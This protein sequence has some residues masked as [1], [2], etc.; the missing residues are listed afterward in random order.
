MTRRR[1]LPW[2]A[3]RGPGKRPARRPVE[4]VGGVCASVSVR[5]SVCVCAR[6]RTGVGVGVGVGLWVRVY[7]RVCVRACVRVYMCSRSSGCCCCCAAAGSGTC[8]VGG[9][10][11][12]VSELAMDSCND[13]GCRDGRSY[14]RRKGVTLC[15]GKKDMVPIKRRK[16]HRPH[17]CSALDVL[18]IRRDDQARWFTPITG[19]SFFITDPPKKH[20]THPLAIEASGFPVR[21]R[22]TP[23]LSPPPGCA[24]GEYRKDWACFDG[25]VGKP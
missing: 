11:D 16:T 20:Q 18:T 7:V 1:T 2:A 3:A 23:A 25:I 5:A 12:T 21:E 15:Q 8:S 4:N 17:H 13:S 6:V 24:A 9:A 22:E 10:G 14:N 19:P